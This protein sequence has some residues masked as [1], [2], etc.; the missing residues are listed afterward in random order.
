MRTIGDPDIRFREDPVRIL[1][2]IKFA[3]RCDL[4]I[5]PETYRRMLEHRQEIAKCAPPRVSRR[6]IGCCAGARPS[7]RWSCCWRPAARHAGARDRARPQ[8]RARRRRRGAATRAVVG[9]PGRARS[10]DRAAPGSAVERADAG[11]AAAAA[12]A[13]RAGSRQQRRPRHRPA[14]GAVDRAGAGA[15]APVAPGQ[16]AGAAD[17]AG[18]ALHPAVER[19]RRRPRLA[20]AISST[21]PCDWPRSSPTPRA[22]DATLAGRP[23]VAEGT[24]VPEGAAAVAADEAGRARC[25]RPSSNRWTPTAGTAAGA[26]AAGAVGRAGDGRERPRRPSPARPAAPPSFPGAQPTMATDLGS[27]ASAVR[28]L[29]TPTCAPPSWATAPS[30]A[31]GPSARTDTPA[32]DAPA[33]TPLRSALRRGRRGGRLPGCPFGLR[34]KAWNRRAEN[35]AA[36]LSYG[37]RDNRAV[38]RPACLPSEHRFT[39][40]DDLSDRPCSTERSSVLRFA[41]RRPG[42]KGCSEG[43]REGR[44]SGGRMSGRP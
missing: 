15:A 1:R 23:I 21:T 24:T 40:L 7:A 44:S 9:V 39:P 17:P 4:T 29:I 5:E 41:G 26:T 18:A 30:A 37:R 22:L 10:L 3:A 35:R 42:A 13:R 25:S 6:S 38:N 8:G 2:A 12:A 31:P 19:P 14:R 34:S 28:T 20:T 11:G 27:L 32:T 16:R 43:R 33:Y 36:R